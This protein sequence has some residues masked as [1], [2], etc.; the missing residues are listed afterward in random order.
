M[1]N[2]VH[3]FSND[4]LP[5]AE[6]LNDEFNNICD[7]FD[8]NITADDL[9]MSTIPVSSK[10]INGSLYASIAGAVAAASALNLDVW[11]PAGT[12]ATDS[13]PII[14]P[15]GMSIEGSHVN[16]VIITPKTGYAHPAFFIIS[17]DHV[18]L[19]NLTLNS[20]ATWGTTSTEYAA[21]KIIT[22]DTTELNLGIVIKN[23]V[24]NVDTPVP[25]GVTN[26][27][28]LI[29]NDVNGVEI[30]SCT[31]NADA[32][33]ILMYP[34]QIYTVSNILITNSKINYGRILIM[35]VLTA[36]Y[37]GQII[38]RNCNFTS[39]AVTTYFIDSNCGGLIEGCRFYIHAGNTTQLAY[40]RQYGVPGQVLEWS[41]C[42]CQCNETLHPPYVFTGAKSSTL[43][44]N[45]ALIG[46]GTY[47]YVVHSFLSGIDALVCTLYN[48][49]FSRVSNV[50]SN[51]L[52]EP[53]PMFTKLWNG[54]RPLRLDDV[55]VW[56]YNDGTF[57]YLCF[58]Q[59]AVPTS[60]TDFHA[61]VKMD[62]NTNDLTD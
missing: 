5:T 53:D 32:S 60:G 36:G 29:S 7:K 10:Y 51:V 61:Y 4:E 34:I 6:L 49:T 50:G 46:T 31:L 47:T 26:S 44:R 24:I 15:A 38:V 13:E 59:G 62:G 19:A 17:G 43:I 48:N 30:D 22:A 16:T 1:L 37:V 21:I 54:L 25:S 57:N 23:V 8:G 45:I 40:I 41:N 55:Y 35:S 2:R 9:E 42:V 33:S 27:C 12:Y 39:G 20:P 11:L 28:I 18:R 3:V 52:L 14:I 56:L 58:K